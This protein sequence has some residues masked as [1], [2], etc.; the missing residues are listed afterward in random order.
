MVVG[1]AIVVAA[2]VAAVAVVVEV[3]TG[4]CSLAASEGWTSE[5]TGVVWV[6]S[7]GCSSTP[8]AACSEEVSR[9]WMIWS[10]KRRKKKNGQASRT[11]STP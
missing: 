2:G 8:D 3:G 7:G 6:V 11:T 10:G 4:A 5:G 1:R 9:R